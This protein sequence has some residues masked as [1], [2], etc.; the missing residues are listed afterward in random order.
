MKRTKI[1]DRKLPDY[2]KGEEIFNM[3][4]HIVG[5]GIGVIATVLC[6]VFAAM[7]KNVYGIISGAIFGVMMIVLYTMSSIYHGLRPNTAKKVLQV[8]DHCSIY[9]LIA[10]TYTPFC[11]CSLRTY[12]PALGWTVF[13]IIWG[14]AALGVIL[15]AID[16]RKF[17][18]VSM[19]LYIGMGWCVIFTVR[20]IIEVLG[21][22]GFLLLLAG[23]V[24]YTVGAIFYGIGAKKRYIHSV[25]HLFVV[26]GSIL[27]FLCIL[28]FVM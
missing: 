18:T 26:L 22:V 25:F 14:L 1:K 15:N 3:V 5:G 13:G 9:L 2:T 21:T 11:L 7:H 19:V 4:S 24:S 28:L 6:V 23:G 17:R 12:N 10:G 27:H 16:L 8:I 20:I